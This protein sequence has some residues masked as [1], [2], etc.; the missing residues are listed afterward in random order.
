MLG[1]GKFL[2]KTKYLLLSVI[3]CFTQNLFAE[4]IKSKIFNYNNNLKNTSA[5]FIQNDLKNIQE[6]QI[7]FGLDRIKINY[8][9]PESL[10]IILSEKKGMYTNHTLRETQ[11]FNTNKSYIKI[12]FKILKSDDF[13]EELEIK[14]G[15]I[16]INDDFVL[17]KNTYEIK[18]IYENNPINLRKVIIIENDQKTEISFF[19]H[20]TLGVYNKKFFSM[21]D[22][23][24]N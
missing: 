5:L 23:Y 11:Y 22:P 8:M 14:E 17:N 7:Y 21:I 19:N 2:E 4:T 12:F 1:K 10:T 15:F 16:E 13:H 18:I 24:L 9:K 3:I 20:N 6:G